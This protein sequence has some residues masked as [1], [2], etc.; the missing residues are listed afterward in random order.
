MYF[1]FF[2][3]SKETGTKET[4]TKE[5]G[6]KTDRRKSTKQIHKINDTEADRLVT[7]VSNRLFGFF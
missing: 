4:G 1:T 7:T 5:T 6:T 3:V 2:P